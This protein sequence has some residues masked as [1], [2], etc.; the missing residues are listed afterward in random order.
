MT[1]LL[2]ACENT[3]VEV[4][5]PVEEQE[6]LFTQVT[7]GLVHTCALA[8]D[9]SAWCWGRGATGALGLDTL[10]SAPVPR[11]VATRL[12]FTSITAG[13]EHTCAT[14]VA[15][16]VYCWGQ[17]SRGKLGTGF[18]GTAASPALIPLLGDSLFL[19]VSAGGGHTCGLT[20]NHD[21]SCW[22]RGNHGELGTGQ[23]Q[24]VH[25]P[26]ATIP[27]RPQGV[28]YRDVSA[29]LHHTCALDAEGVTLCWGWGHHGQ[30]GVGSNVT[31]G[32]PE[33]VR[34]VP[35]F[36][37]ISAG[38]EHTCALSADGTAWCWGRGDFGQL[39]DGTG[40]S[41][42]APVRVAGE[43]RFT[44][45]SAGYEHTCAIARDGAAWCWGE[46]SRGR[47]GSG[48]ATGGPQTRPVR[49][50]GNS[51]FQSIAA[52][53]QHSCAVSTELRV[54][55]WGFGGFGQLGAGALADR[56]APEPVDAPR[57]QLPR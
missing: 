51:R 5:P 40:T 15:G 45:I 8:V 13:E 7:A 18:L 16:E 30:L 2:A 4:M 55:C 24:D 47:L 9:G 52:G 46:G 3:P 43:V 36:T 41:R 11:A 27:A 22:G 19:R 25:R 23:L 1:V 49:V 54:S 14:T 31:L 17:G 50:A 10:I 12:T 57:G 34:D 44:A 20:T 53:G 21:I 38:R 56:Y 26:R 37:S 28:P 33:R 32:F 42:P 29:G 48:D 6:L 39:G 35:A